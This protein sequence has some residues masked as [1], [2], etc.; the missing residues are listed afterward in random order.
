MVS[1]D[2]PIT[3]GIEEEFFLI[4]PETRDLLADPDPGI[5]EECERTRGPHMVVPEALRAQIETNTKVCESIAELRT[6]VAETRRLVIEAAA[7]HGAAV[8]ACSMHPFARWQT[9]MTTPK[10]RYRQFEISFQDSMRRLLIGGMHVHAGFGDPDTRI[11]VMTALRRHLPLLLAVSTSSPFHAGRETGFKSYRLS[12]FG[13]LPRTGMP[14]P[15]S[16]RAEFDELIENYQRM[17][18]I[19][20]GSELWWDIRPSHKY[21][22][23]ELRI[24]DVCPRIEDA[25]GIA[26]LYAALLRNLLRRARE[27]RLEAEPL[28]E[29]ILENR[30]V[31]QRY[32]VLGF[33]GDLADEGRIDIQDY[34]ARLLDDLEEDSRALGCEAEIG[35]ILAIIR[36]GSA[37][38]HQVDHY[39][40]RRLEGDSDEEA[41]R[42]VVDLMIAETRHG[43]GAA[44]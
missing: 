19:G 14:G 42:S 35:R 4:D 17:N 2:I 24:C 26:A 8:L 32:G 23:I 27:G 44:T 9:Q 33:L 37:A 18:F 21:P 25:I 34:A 31:A 1:G 40:L 7:K 13:T 30:W 3:L 20:D 16:S 28:T 10:E 38:D 12:I 15:L 5:F 22:T 11:E 36:D 6:A 41:L 43:S 39:R 29:L